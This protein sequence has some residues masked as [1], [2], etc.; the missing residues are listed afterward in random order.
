MRKDEFLKRLNKALGSLDAKERA[1]TVQ[2][3]REILEDRME[4]GTP[5][6]DAVAALG[7]VEQIAADISRTEQNSADAER[8]S[9]K[10]KLM[11]FFERKID[12]G[13]SFE[14]VI[15]SVSNHGYFVE[16][17]QSMAYGF[18]HVH[19]LRDD[20]YHV[21][22][23]GGELRGRRTGETFKTGDKVRVEV[24]SVDRFKRQIDFRL[25]ASSDSASR[26]KKRRKR[27]S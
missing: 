5:E 13:E 16:L 24:E 22:G 15:E 18:V 9:R 17:T 6:E 12:T 3:Y 7:P 1:R 26:A 8:E 27:N 10:I 19:N 11:E 21:S 2:Y 4:D 25:A 23:E 20:F 14:A